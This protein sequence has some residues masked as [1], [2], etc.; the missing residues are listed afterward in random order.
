[1]CITLLG[2]QSHMSLLVDCSS[3]AYT[4][5]I[6]QRLQSLLDSMGTLGAV[7]QIASLLQKLAYHT[8]PSWLVVTPNAHLPFI[9]VLDGERTPV[10]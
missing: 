1:M 6:T 2:S 4:H 10:V 3:C 9:L 8:E 7:Q 5:S